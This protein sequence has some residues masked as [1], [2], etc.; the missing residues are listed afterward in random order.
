MRTMINYRINHTLIILVNNRC[1]GCIF[2]ELIFQWRK[3]PI[4]MKFVEIFVIE[5]YQNSRC[6]FLLDKLISQEN[7]YICIIRKEDYTTFPENH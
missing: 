2:V 7:R 3:I 4:M 1:N 5:R 6:F